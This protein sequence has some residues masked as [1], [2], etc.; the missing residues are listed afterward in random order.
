MP[1]SGG[2]SYDFSNCPS[3]HFLKITTGSESENSVPPTSI[4]NWHERAQSSREK[5]R[6]R[7]QSEEVDLSHQH[8]QKKTSDQPAMDMEEPE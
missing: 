5:M 4:E 6:D 1:K 2:D 8:H 7:A 3:A